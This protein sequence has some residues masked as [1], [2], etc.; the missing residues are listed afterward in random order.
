MSMNIG[1]LAIHAGTIQNDL[2]KIA[3]LPFNVPMKITPQ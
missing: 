2:I 1:M 3:K